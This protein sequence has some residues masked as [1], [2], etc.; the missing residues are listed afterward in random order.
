[1]VSKGWARDCR[2][3]RGAAIKKYIPDEKSPPKLALIGTPVAPCDPLTR[4][5]A[6]FGSPIPWTEA[7]RRT[8]KEMGDDECLGLA[9]RLASY[10]LPALFPL[11]FLVA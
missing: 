10:F 9:A 3:H 11:L 6:C 5:F 8:V 7:I 1:V 2:P 4:M